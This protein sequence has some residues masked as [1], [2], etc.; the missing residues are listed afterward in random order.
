MFDKYIIVGEEFKNVQK[1][2]K[3]TGFQVGV[4][5]PYYRG[6]QVSQIDDLELSLDGEPVP[7]ETITVTLHGHTYT[8]DEFLNEDDDRWEF[9]EVGVLTVRKPGGLTPGRHTLALAPYLR[10]GY[11]PQTFAGRDTKTLA[12]AGT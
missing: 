12:I 1:D 7:R 11:W 5:I 8:L 4:R 3:V 10:I 6:I 9:G 2:G